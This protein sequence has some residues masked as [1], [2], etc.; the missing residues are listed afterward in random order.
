M[1][2]IK[3]EIQELVIQDTV[4]DIESSKTREGARLIAEQLGAEFENYGTQESYDARVK[5]LADK[6][7]KVQKIIRIRPSC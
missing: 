1:N 2:E 7:A 6:G 4:I 5:E 3:T